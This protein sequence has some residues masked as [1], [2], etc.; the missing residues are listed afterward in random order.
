M[1]AG[2]VNRCCWLSLQDIMA[3][4]EFLIDSRFSFEELSLFPGV[5]KEVREGLEVGDKIYLFGK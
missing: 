1:P 3:N 4:F 5:L 2:R